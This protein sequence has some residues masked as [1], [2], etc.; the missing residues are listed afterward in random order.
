MFQICT[1]S[2]QGEYIVAARDYGCN[3]FMI[4]GRDLS[5]QR[6]ALV[7][8]LGTRQEANLLKILNLL[9]SFGSLSLIGEINNFDT[10]SS[11]L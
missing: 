6:N 2:V 3:A 1:V 9:K 8:R 7:L 5:K 4:V 11:V 10:S